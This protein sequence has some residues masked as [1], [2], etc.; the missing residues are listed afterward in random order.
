VQNKP[1]LYYPGGGGGNW[2]NYLIW[3][4]LSQQHANHDILE[5]SLKNIKENVTQ[6]FRIIPHS[7]YTSPANVRFGSNQA[8]IN[9][10]INVCV[11]NPEWTGAEPGGY[12]RMKEH[13]WDWNL[14]YT[15]IFLDAEGFLEQLNNLTGFNIK[16][17]KH[18]KHAFDQYRQSCPWYGMTESNLLETKWVTDSWQHCFDFRTNI[19]DSIKIRKEQ[20]WD[21]VRSCL[22]IIQPND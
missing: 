4:G 11:K 15:K 1:L 8:L 6:Y 14:D 21:E 12:I 10:Y 13:D 16:L 19:D 5:F 2:L 3:C 7:E 18:T 22:L 20:A 17:D 9:F